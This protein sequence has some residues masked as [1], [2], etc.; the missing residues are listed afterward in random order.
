MVCP[1]SDGSR[2]LSLGSTAQSICLLIWSSF[3]HFRLPLTYRLMQIILRPFL[4]FAILMEEG[5]QAVTITIILFQF[6]TT[7]KWKWIIH[8]F[9]HRAPPF[10]GYL[11]PLWIL[12]LVTPSKYNAMETTR[13]SP[14]SQLLADS[15]PL[16]NIL[17][18]SSLLFPIA[19]YQHSALH[20]ALSRPL[21]HGLSTSSC[22]S[23]NLD[24][25]H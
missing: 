5:A 12:P 14:K 20:H 18:I 9:T 13:I 4:S 10:L 19:S 15:T 24:N 3:S 23:S 11:F 8:H 25:T 7:S 2:V 21:S 1:K 17:H 6:W 16:K 22:S